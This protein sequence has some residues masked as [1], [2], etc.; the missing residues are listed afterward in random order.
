MA[1][2]ARAFSFSSPPARRWRN[3]CCCAV[4]QGIMTCPTTACFN[5]LA[6]EKQIKVGG[7]LRYFGDGFQI[8]KLL[9]GRRLWRI[10]VM[11]GEFVI[12]ETFDMAKSVGGGNFLVLGESAEATLAA[13]EAAVTAMQQRARRH[14]A[15][16]GWHRAQRQ[17]SGLPV[18]VPDGL[19][20]HGLLPDPAGPGG[21]R[22]ARGRELGAG[23]RHRRADRSGRAEAMR[24]GIEAACQPGI[25]SIYGRELWRQV[26][27]VPDPSAGVVVMSKTI[28]RLQ[29]Q[30]PCR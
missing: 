17:Q 18:Q 16:P 23:D 19:H 10:P 4:G 13:T 26:G 29:E 1:G 15:L 22:P 6:G 24:V 28:L 7:A 8:S 25:V 27:P 9:E 14:P 20:Q 12:D 2:P 21:Q 11:E 3:N 30:S 5:G